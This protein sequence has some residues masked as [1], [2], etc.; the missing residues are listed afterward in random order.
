MKAELLLL[1][2]FVKAL[3]A[4]NRK[5]SIYCVCANEKLLLLLFIVRL[6]LKINQVRQEILRNSLFSIVNSIFLKIP[7]QVIPCNNRN[8]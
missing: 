7:S 1:A 6:S 4:E 5:S 2:L 3:S 8:S